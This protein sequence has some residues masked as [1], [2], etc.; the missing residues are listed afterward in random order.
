[1]IVLVILLIVVILLVAIAVAVVVVA[2]AIVALVSSSPVI[3]VV[4]PGIVVM[5]LRPS[6]LMTRSGGGLAAERVLG[7]D[8]IELVMRPLVVHVGLGDPSGPLGS[9]STAATAKAGVVAPCTF[10]FVSNNNCLKRAP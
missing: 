1:M 4:C 10:H 2:S 7:S 3:A 5:M 8:L 6:I 9:G